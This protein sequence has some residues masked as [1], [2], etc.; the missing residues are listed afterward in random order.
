MQ[1]AQEILSGLDKEVGSLDHTCSEDGNMSFH[2]D[3]K[4]DD[5]AVNQFAP[6]LDS[7]NSQTHFHNLLLQLPPAVPAQ[8][9]LARGFSR[10]LQTL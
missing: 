8:A 9:Q 2:D 5:N 7:A 3:Y 6:G 1:Y 4:A 10:I